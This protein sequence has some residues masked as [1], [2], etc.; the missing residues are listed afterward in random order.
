MELI[1]GGQIATWDQEKLIYEPDLKIDKIVK[2]N[3][4]TSQEAEK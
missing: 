2:E 4:K 1:D 3:A